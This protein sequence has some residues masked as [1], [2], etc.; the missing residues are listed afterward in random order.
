M[1]NINKSW[2]YLKYTTLCCK[3]KKNKKIRV[4]TILLTTYWS[5]V[6]NCQIKWWNVSPANYIHPS[7]YPPCS[8]F[9]GTS[10]PEG[11][12]ASF[13]LL[14]DF[15]GIN[16]QHGFVGKHFRLRNGF[17][18]TCCLIGFAGICC[19]NGFAET[20]CLGRSQ[21]PWK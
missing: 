15:D 3:D 19:R 5:T 14:I 1:F 17:D 6:L 20:N 4:C 2:T 9:D 16:F 11:I 10:S 21:Y 13:R 18:G 7:L 12:F 8:Y